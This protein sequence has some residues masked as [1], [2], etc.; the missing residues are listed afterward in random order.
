MPCFIFNLFSSLTL[1][2]IADYLRQIIVHC[3]AHPSPENPNKTPSSVEGQTCKTA[4]ISICHSQNPSV[5][6]TV[7]PIRLP[8]IPF[9]LSSCKLTQI[10][11]LLSTAENVQF[12]QSS[13][14]ANSL[15]FCWESLS[16]K[17]LHLL[18]H[19]SF[20]FRSVIGVI[21]LHWKLIFS[22]YESW[23]F[24]WILL[25]VK[26]SLR[27]FVLCDCVYRHRFVV[28]VL[29]RDG[30]VSFRLGRKNCCRMA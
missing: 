4:N 20:A 11:T 1:T 14:N 6:N 27:R 3:Q 8:S 22:I 13:L 24:D 17:S 30:R 15:F 7:T 25:P 23:S 19:W 9:C 5:H 28:C 10:T 29:V 21:M 16:G 26:F 12:V 2:Q 18:F